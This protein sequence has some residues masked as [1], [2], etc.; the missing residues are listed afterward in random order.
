MVKTF[1]LLR[2]VVMDRSEWARTGRWEAVWKRLGQNHVDHSGSQRQ[3]S[4]HLAS[5]ARQADGVVRDVARRH[6]TAFGSLRDSTGCYL[7][8]G[9]AAGVLVD[10]HRAMEDRLRGDSVGLLYDQYGMLFCRKKECSNH[11]VGG[12]S[13]FEIDTR[14]LVRTRLSQLE[15]IGAVSIREVVNELS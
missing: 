3:G 10:D 14:L 2:S 9:V 13:I 1:L 6:D 11:C 12:G 7:A 4:Y 15:G 8:L 5:T